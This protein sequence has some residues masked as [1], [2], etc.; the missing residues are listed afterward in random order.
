MT[1]LGTSRVSKKAAVARAFDD[2]SLA[3]LR[4]RLEE[5]PSRYVGLLD[6]LNGHLYRT[7]R[8]EELALHGVGRRLRVMQSCIHDF[9]RNLPPEEEG[10]PHSDR[11]TAAIV[12]MHAF[13]I[14]VY[15]CL[16]NLAGVWVH[17][18]DVR[19]D[20]GLPLPNKKIGFRKKNKT[21]LRSLPAALSKQLTDSEEW[22]EGLENFRDALAHRIP[23]YIPPYMVTESRRAEFQ[24]LEAERLNAAWNLKFDEERE[25]EARQMKV[26]HFRPI[27]THSFTE[28]ARSVIVHGQMFCDFLTIEQL[29]CQIL[30]ALKAVPRPSE[31]PT[32]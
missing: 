31:K 7:E 2:Q 28:G 27:S 5:L 8:G 1:E 4:A 21:V 13:T 29:T 3:H 15:G 26:A 20:N 10:V 18:C 9:F 17:E 12:S 19:G 11:V 6:R 24:K 30:D 14:H 16:D 23:P 32:K 25:L 22:M